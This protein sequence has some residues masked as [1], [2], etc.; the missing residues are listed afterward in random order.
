MVT[1]HVLHRVITGMLAPIP[2]ELSN[3]PKFLR[4]FYNELVSEYSP[5]FHQ[6]K[7]VDGLVDFDKTE[8]EGEVFEKVFMG[9][10]HHGSLVS[11][12][13][14]ADINGSVPNGRLTNVEVKM[15]V[16]L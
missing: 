14:P 2:D 1:D 9:D 8:H 7:C 4:H 10:D 5:F 3:P 13:Q 11:F 12:Y 6:D 16:S 15:Q